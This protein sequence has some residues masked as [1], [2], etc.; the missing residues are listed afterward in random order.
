M[1]HFYGL[2]IGLAIVVGWSVAEKIEPKVNLIAPWVIFFGIIG[3]RIYHVIDNFEYYDQN[4]LS[5][6]KIWEGGMSIWGALMGGILAILIYHYII[7]SIDHLWEIM[8]AIVSGL[9]LAQAIGRL[10]NGVNG[11]FVNEVW[12]LPWWGMEAMLDLILFVL[13]RGVSSKYRVWVYLVGYGLIR[14]FLQ[15]YR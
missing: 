1:F 14:L 4:L 9:P 5:I 10:G 2:F 8:G 6:V 3:A 12:I 15:P 13:L 11:E 7:K